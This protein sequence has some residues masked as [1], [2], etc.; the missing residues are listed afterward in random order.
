[1]ITYNW[2]KEPTYLL[3]VMKMF[4]FTEDNLLGPDLVIRPEAC[5][6]LNICYYLE[7]KESLYQ[8]LSPIF[9]L[10]HRSWQ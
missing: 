3:F 5:A 10:S 7:S 6:T 9:P 1:M 4:T 8:L 2:F